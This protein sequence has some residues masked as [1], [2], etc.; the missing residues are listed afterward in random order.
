MPITHAICEI[1]NGFYIALVV[2]GEIPVP[3]PKTSIASPLARFDH[4]DYSTKSSPSV[5]GE[6]KG[7]RISENVANA[8]A[9]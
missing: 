3:G 9:I 2:G 4:A 6:K 7:S 5:K 1:V 8:L